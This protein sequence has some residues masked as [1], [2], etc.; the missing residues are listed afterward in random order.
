MHT[1]QGGGMLCIPF[2]V[3]PKLVKFVKHRVFLLAIRGATD[4]GCSWFNCA[5][6]LVVACFV[7]NGS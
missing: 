3:S 4:I 5:L 6:G 2:N 1:A 7:R